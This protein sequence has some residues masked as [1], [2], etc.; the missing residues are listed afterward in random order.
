MEHAFVCSICPPGGSG[1]PPPEGR[2]P[3]PRV[4]PWEAQTTLLGPHFISWFQVGSLQPRTVKGFS[5]DTRPRQGRRGTTAF[6][7]S[8]AVSSLYPC[9]SSLSRQH[10]S[11]RTGYLG[12]GVH[13][14]LVLCPREALTLSQASL[15]DAGRNLQSPP[16]PSRLFYTQANTQR[17]ARAFMGTGASRSNFKGL[18]LSFLEPLQ[19]C[20]FDPV[21]QH[22]EPLLVSQRQFAFRE[23]PAH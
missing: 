4:R 7:S 16:P 23:L 9:A 3:A 18:L 13:G 6:L 14:T 19:N 1:W 22:A 20:L 10:P 5:Q 17:K 12:D 15:T 11:P 2:E 21:Q 8:P